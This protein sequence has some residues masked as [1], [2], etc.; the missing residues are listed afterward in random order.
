MTDS[1]TTGTTNTRKAMEQHP[2]TAKT[3]II[4]NIKAL[5]GRE[6]LHNSAI[7]FINYATRGLV[8]VVMQHVTSSSRTDN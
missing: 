3:N 1:C 8:V 2:T 7:C 6:M 5:F 4:S